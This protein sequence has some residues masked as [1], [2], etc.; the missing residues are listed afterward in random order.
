MRTLVVYYSLSG[1]TRAIATVIAREL[2]AD[3]EEIGC[4]TYSAGGW[5]YIRAAIDSLRGKLPPIE[6]ISR[7]PAEYDLVVIGGPVWASHLATPARAFLQRYPQLPAV[8]FFV[9]QGGSGAE[10]A[11][12][13]MKQ[14][15]GGEPQATLIVREQD[16]KAGGYGPAVSAFA[17]KLGKAKVA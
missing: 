5:S 17:S 12:R 7:S 3:L 13:E 1:N 6:P 15:T 9:T 16:V 8:A 14:L 2:G 11:F 10:R 4:G